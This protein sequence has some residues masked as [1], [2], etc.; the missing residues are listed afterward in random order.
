[1]AR[2]SNGL[3]VQTV[4]EYLEEDTLEFSP[5]SKGKKKARG[6]P[7]P[8]PPRRLSGL[9][10]AGLVPKTKTQLTPAYKADFAITLNQFSSLTGIAYFA[11]NEYF[12]AREASP[13]P[14][15]ELSGPK[16]TSLGILSRNPNQNWM[17]T[18]SIS[19]QNEAPL[20]VFTD[21]GPWPN[22]KTAAE[23]VAKLGLEWLQVEINEL[24]AKT[25]L[26]NLTATATG[27]AIKKAPATVWSPTRALTVATTSASKA[28]VTIVTEA[29]VV[30]TLIDNG[31]V[32]GPP[33][34]H[35]N[36][37]VTLSINEEEALKVENWVGALN[38][39]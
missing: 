36:G 29:E 18:L 11:L 10:V 13:K 20:K 33:I 35:E 19:A 31:P 7:P 3:T 32:R 15:S 2:G 6:P 25:G 34:P 16:T 14:P 27:G 12:E 21:P 9:S 26:A 5:Q 23:K 4:E 17:A 30:N 38:R 8:I 22:K 39:G 1:M 24:Q 37:V 28:G